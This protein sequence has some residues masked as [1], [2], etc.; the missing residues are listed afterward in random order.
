MSKTFIS[1]AVFFLMICAGFK[2]VGIRQGGATA[3]SVARGKEVY[4]QVCLSC[5]QVDGGG[6]PNMIPPLIKTKYVIGDKKQLINILLNG[7]QGDVEVNG[8]FYHNVM[9]PQSTLTDQQIADVLTFVRN[10]FTNK[11]TAVKVTE[12]KAMRALMPKAK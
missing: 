8:D 9:P 10:S 11:A 6:V 3:V 12:V 2:T 7:L 5:H 4:T 1:A